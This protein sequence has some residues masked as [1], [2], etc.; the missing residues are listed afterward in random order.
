MVRQ[1]REDLDSNSFFL[2]AGDTGQK[3]VF[4]VGLKIS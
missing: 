2:L 1:Q 4:Q 3:I